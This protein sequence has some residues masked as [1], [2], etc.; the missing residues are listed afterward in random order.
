MG[1]VLRQDAL[2]IT[3]TTLLN[4]DSKVKEGVVFLGCRVCIG[5]VYK[6]RSRHRP[7]PSWTAHSPAMFTTAAASYKNVKSK[8]SVPFL[9]VPGHRGYPP[10][11]AFKSVFVCLWGLNFYFSFFL[12]AISINVNHLLRTLLCCTSGTML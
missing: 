1:I 2:R 12:G 10:E 6:G 7:L 11:W 9:A 5:D 3:L 4:F 8:R